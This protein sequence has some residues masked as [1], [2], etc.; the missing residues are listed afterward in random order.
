V[1]LGMTLC[2]GDR[3]SISVLYI[4]QTTEHLLLSFLPFRSPGIAGLFV[5][6]SISMIMTTLGALAGINYCTL[7][8]EHGKCGFELRDFIPKI[9][10]TKA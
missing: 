6:N 10:I 4:D 9:Y 7:E 2:Y 8:V 5:G 3:S 1:E